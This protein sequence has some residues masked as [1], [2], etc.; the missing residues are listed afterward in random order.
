MLRKFRVKNFL[1]FRD[2][3]TL[4]LTVAANA[5]DLPGRFVRSVPG[6]KDRFPTFVAIF[7]ANASG[8]TNIL[9]ALTFVARFVQFSQN[10]PPNQLIPSLPFFGGQSNDEMS[11]F[12]IEIDGAIGE[13]EERVRFH[14]RLAISTDQTHVVEEELKYYPH[15]RPRRLFLRRGQSFEFG[16]DFQ[17]RSNDPSVRK[18]R[19]NGS[20]IS[21]LAQ[22]NH[23]LSVEMLN[24]LSLM[25][26]NV[27][28]VMGNHDFSMDAVS[29][30]YR[31]N[32]HSLNDFLALSGKFDMNIERVEISTSESGLA[33]MFYHCGV[34]VPIHHTF[35]SHGTN[36]I[37]SL[38]PIFNL[39]LQSGSVAF[40]DELDNSIHSLLLPEIIE[41]FVDPERNPNHAQLIAVCQNPS[42]LQ[43]LEKE[44]VFFA[45]KA[46]DGTSSIYG[47]KDIKG[48]R[49]ESNIYANYLAGAFGGVPKVA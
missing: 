17:I 18:I 22:F 37:F 9:R 14:Y 12:E 28:G 34:N 5:P 1:S 21:T 8:K 39:V 45:E 40:V 33:P 4:D 32:P 41:L 10:D 16:E 36:K 19:K 25:Q 20:V 13:M 38:F 29:N 48:V 43:H 44:E 15:N 31:L 6:S 2:W 23:P 30:F 26:S 42:I 35:E 27:A 7:G 11:E 47:M 49:R 3:Q 46:S 24:G